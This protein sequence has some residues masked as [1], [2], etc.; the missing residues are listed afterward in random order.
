MDVAVG[1]SIPKYSLTV[2]EFFFSICHL[3]DENGDAR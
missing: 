1:G 3:I 2:N